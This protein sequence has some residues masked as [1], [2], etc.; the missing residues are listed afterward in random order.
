MR[1]KVYYK[2]FYFIEA[3]SIDDAIETN[4]DDFDVEY[5]EWENVNAE[6]IDG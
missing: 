6:E 3:D 2:G 4:K 1:Y 5:E